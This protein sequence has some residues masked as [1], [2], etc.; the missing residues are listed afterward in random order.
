MEVAEYSQ[1]VFVGGGSYGTTHAI[2]WFLLSMS[3]FLGVL[4]PWRLIGSCG[5]VCGVVCGLVPLGIVRVRLVLCGPGKR[6]SCV[7]VNSSDLFSLIDLEG[8]SAVEVKAENIFWVS[9]CGLL[10]PYKCEMPAPPSFPRNDNS[11]SGAYRACRMV[12]K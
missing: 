7:M 12:P 11:P 9:N 3:S 10:N 6:V 5:L 4:S 8:N 2:S 1:V